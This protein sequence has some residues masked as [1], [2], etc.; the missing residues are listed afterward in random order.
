MTITSDVHD[1][2]ICYNHL[3]RLTCHAYGTHVTQY[4]WTSTASKQART[5]SIIVLATHDPIEYKCMVTGINSESGY[6]SVNISSNGE[7]A[8]Y[9]L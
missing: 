8:L 2:I 7:F 1:G 3:I 5:A 4:K 9:M 6:S